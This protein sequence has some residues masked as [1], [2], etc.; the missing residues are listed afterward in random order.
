MATVKWVLI[1]QAVSGPDW[2]LSIKAQ[3]QL[4]EMKKE[5]HLTQAKD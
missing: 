2:V 3:Q 4:L 1:L 5:Q